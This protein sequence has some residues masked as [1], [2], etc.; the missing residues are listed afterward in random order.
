MKDIKHIIEA[1]LFVAAKP[2]SLADIYAIVKTKRQL[3]K[4]QIENLLKEMENEY[5]DRGLMVV[6]KKEGIFELKVKEHIVKHVEHL[7][8]ERDMTR[9]VIQSLSLIAFKNP[10]KQ[11]VVIELRGNRAYDHIKELESKGFIRAEPSGHTNML[12]ITRKFLDYFGLT[13]QSQVKDYFIDKGVTEESF[14]DDDDESAEEQEPQR[15]PKERVVKQPTVVDSVVEPTET[16]KKDVEDDTNSDK[17]KTDNPKEDN[18][19]DTSDK[20]EP[21]KEKDDYKSPFADVI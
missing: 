15:D 6:E 4:K 2:L 9:A 7:A 19:E 14:I 11:S 8:P 3:T 12:Y 13:S 20:D 17:N 21:K 18:S 10:V 5:D 16:K 1:A